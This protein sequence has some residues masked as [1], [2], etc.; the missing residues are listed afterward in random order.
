MAAPLLEVSANARGP[1]GSESVE[2]VGADAALA[3]LKGALVRK[4]ALTPFAGDRGGGA[5]GAGGEH[6]RA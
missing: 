3:E 1:K 6:A 5:A 4:V 2:L